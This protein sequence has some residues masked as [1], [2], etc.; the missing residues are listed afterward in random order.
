MIADFLPSFVLFLREGLEASLIIS[1]LLTVV[2]QLGMKRSALPI[3]LGVGTAIIGS[4]VFAALFQQTVSS[5]FPTYMQVFQTLTFLAAAIIVTW[6]T[7]WVQQHSRTLK[8]E[9]TERVRRSSSV[10]VLAL[11]AF[12]TV[13]REGLETAIFTLAFANADTNKTMLLLGALLGTLAAVSLGILIY[14]FGYRLN[15]RIFFRVMG[16]LLLVMAASLLSHAVNGLQT[17]GWIS[18]G[19]TELWNMIGSDWLGNSTV[20]GSLLSIFG[21]YTEQATILQMICY[22]IFLLVFTSLFWRATRA[23]RRGPTRQLQGASETVS[24]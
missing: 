10:F 21:G 11:L 2:H 16:L 3:W 7:F 12:T 4:F 1:I 17:L 13:G 14:R 24:M 20:P 18:F 15:Y 22:V 6:M 19:T 23:P 9:I 8:Q 5:A